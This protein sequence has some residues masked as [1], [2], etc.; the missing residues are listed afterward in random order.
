MN[1]FGVASFSYYTFLCKETARMAIITSL[2]VKAY[3]STSCQISK[4]VLLIVFYE[5]SFRSDIV[6]YNVCITFIS[7]YIKFSLFKFILDRLLVKKCW[8]GLLNIGCL[9]YTSPSPR[10][11][12]LSRMPSS[13]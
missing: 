5:F 13:A 4:L 12:L 6:G 7:Y 10:D 11:G 9:L 8:D 2:S 1:A 3:V